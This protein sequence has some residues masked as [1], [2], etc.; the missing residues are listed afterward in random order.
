[1]Y[2]VSVPISFNTL[3]E[4]NASVYI[5][6]AK[7][8]GVKR[9]FFCG[10]GDICNKNGILYTDT[11]R[12]QNIINLFKENNF[13]TGV[14]V[15]A[16]GHGAALLH[17][18]EF[19]DTFT[20]MVGVDGRVG[21]HA[22]CPSDE[23]FK[24]E[25][26]GSLKRIALLGPDMIM[27][28]DDFRFNWRGCYY[29]GC[30]CSYHLN[31]FYKKIGEE[32]PLEKIEELIYTGGKNKYR[33]A[34][35][36]L[37]RESLI[38]FAKALRNAVDAVDSSIRMGI[39]STPDN[40]DNSGTDMIELSKVIAGN[41]KPFTRIFHAPYDD[42]NIIPAIEAA[43]M[44]FEWLD[45]TGIECFAEG[46][47]YPRPRYNVPSK[48]LELF[49]FAL[50]AGGKGDGILNYVYDYSQKPDYET[51]YVDRY[52]KNQPVRDK[53]NEL[54]AGKKA[55]GV[56]VFNVMHKVEDQEF[57]EVLFKEIVRKLLNI[58]SSPAR[59]LIS[60]N[61]IPTTYD[62]GE[63]PLL[64]LG[65]NARY[66]KKEDLSNGAILDASA[67]KILNK[68]GIDTGLIS[69][70]IS[71]FD[72]EYFI[73]DKDTIRN[74]NNTGLMKIKCSEK[75]EILS[76]F[77]PDNTP[78]SY[79]Y[80][81]SDG[82]KFYV[83]AYDM[84]FEAEN[85]SIN[86]SNNYYRQAQIINAIEWLCGKKLP[87][88]CT[89]NPGLYILSS[90]DESAMSVM[91]LNISLDDILNPEIKLDKEYKEIKFVNCSGTLNGDTVTLSDITPYG[92]AMF[93]VK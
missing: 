76:Y 15:S 58:V 22:N 93:E 85:Y 46:D 92:L 81:N 31:E 27:F 18:K 13:E 57:P 71:S 56:S 36:E 90:K 84:F 67:A 43:R 48:V 37:M 83:L 25:Y 11:K 78:A 35:R 8:S 21:T 26:C 64:L 49:D 51:G 55:V 30:F 66:V 28:D 73:K 65:E 91:L 38:D 29:M 44:Q 9:V 69:S 89:K 53:I 86:Y 70:E 47:V 24:N 34:Y 12:L 4:E 62:K 42:I 1:M 17:Q 16:F 45:G 23:N 87:A 88:T 77:T 59:F 41:T 10:F 39:C 75:A 20:Q 79:L 33:T 50:M 60:Q 80:E 19:A 74:I 32:I 54:F 3:T 2:K 5:D 52:I 6:S 61:S 7:K 40:W 63:Y 68:R 72:G 82:L 14:W